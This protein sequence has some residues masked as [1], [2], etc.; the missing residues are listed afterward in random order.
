MTASAASG[1][2]CYFNSI[3]VQLKRTHRRGTCR[4]DSFQFHKGTIKALGLLNYREYRICNFNS[5]KVQLKRRLLRSAA[6]GATLFQFHK[7]TIK[8]RH[9]VLR[10]KRFHVDFNSIKVQLKQMA[11]DNPTLPALFQFHK[12]TIKARKVLFLASRMVISI[13]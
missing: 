3:K 7:G 11:T 10:R 4:D 2:L 13:P 1:V 6:G 5:I 12:G 9:F 8:A